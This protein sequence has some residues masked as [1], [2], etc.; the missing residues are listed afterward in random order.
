[1][2]L[3]ELIVNNQA[4]SDENDYLIGKVLKQ[5]DLIEEKINPLIETCEG[6]HKGFLQGLL[7]EISKLTLE[8]SRGR[9][10]SPYISIDTSFG[11][12]SLE[13][14]RNRNTLLKRI[15]QCLQSH[16]LFQDQLIRAF[17]VSPRKQAL[18][19]SSSFADVAKGIFSDL[20]S[21]FSGG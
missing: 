15:N 10:L 21:F 14:I 7:K 13:F 5:K 19:R 4:L 2:G 20:S 16:Y 8:D 1:M 9:N 6:S 3:Q 18:T 17:A 12:C 11:E